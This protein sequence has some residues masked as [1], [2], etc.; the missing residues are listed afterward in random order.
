MTTGHGPSMAGDGRAGRS[1]VDMG[2][3][4]TSN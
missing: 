3:L 1:L 2:M 4:E